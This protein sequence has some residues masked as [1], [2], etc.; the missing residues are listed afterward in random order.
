MKAKKDRMAAHEMG[1]D[2]G[3]KK[4]TKEP[5][6]PRINFKYDS[7]LGLFGF[8]IEAERQSKREN[9]ELMRIAKKNEEF[10]EIAR[11]RAHV[12]Y[13][14]GVMDAKTFLPGDL[15]Q[16][17]K[18]KP[19]P[20]K[21]KNG[22][23]IGKAAHDHGK[24]RSKSDFKGNNQR[25]AGKARRISSENRNMEPPHSI[26]E[27]DIVSSFNG[28]N[29]NGNAMQCSPID[30]D[31]R[32]KRKKSV[33]MN[34]AVVMNDSPAVYD[35]FYNDGSDF[36]DNY[37]NDDVLEVLEVNDH[38]KDHPSKP[39]RKGT[40]P[41]AKTDVRGVK[42]SPLRLSAIKK[43][44]Q[45]EIESN[46]ESD[47]FSLNAKPKVPKSG[48]KKESFQRNRPSINRSKPAG[49]K[50]RNKKKSKSPRRSP[51]KKSPCK[52]AQGHSSPGKGNKQTKFDIDV[53]DSVAGAE[54]SSPPK[55]KSQ[56]K[57]PTRFLK[58]SIK[59]PK[60]SIA[61]ELFEEFE[62]F[63]LNDD[64]STSNYAK[65]KNSSAVSGLPMSKT[66]DNEVFR[67]TSPS[68]PQRSRVDK[69][70]MALYAVKSEGTVDKKKDEGLDDYNDDGFDDYDEDILFDFSHHDK[71]D[72]EKAL[73]EELSKKAQEEAET[74]AREK[75]VKEAEMEK[76]RLE[77]EKR[78]AVEREEQR[79]AR[80]LA[81]E[82]EEAERIKRQEEI[83][84]D[85]SE[86][87]ESER[88]E[89]RRRQARL[90]E[91]ELA[92]KER[93]QVER[94]MKKEE[95]RLALIQAEQEA[96][97]EKQKEKEA[98]KRAAMERQ[99]KEIE[100]ARIAAE[101][102]EE[103]ERRKRI[104]I[105]KIKEEKL[106]K[107]ANLELERLPNVIASP[108]NIEGGNDEME[109]INS[110]QDDNYNFDEDFEDDPQVKSDQD[111]DSSSPVLFEI[112][113]PIR[114]SVGE[115]DSKSHVVS[116]KKDS[117]PASSKSTIVVEEVGLDN[118]HKSKDDD[119]VL[120]DFNKPQVQSPVVEGENISERLNSP[121]GNP[122]PNDEE[123]VVEDYESEYDDDF[124]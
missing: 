52:V 106:Q 1:I 5:V 31:V 102:K 21:V 79:K 16:Q 17:I 116:P 27:N 33:Q 36:I 82:K 30:G 53:F 57:S 101:E 78:K 72:E 32:K 54:K 69:E 8:D 38:D 88:M 6:S 62:A 115:S 41:P 56:T 103:E 24:L 114:T 59:E 124:D 13:G 107:A 51:R 71:T 65:S 66:N 96:V 11:A 89:E 7:R 68:S 108:K 100:D 10:A 86:R 112:N 44:H 75:T 95:E 28:G 111:I 34:P 9:Y 39:K 3:G 94:E 20:K 105:D 117:E 70:Q 77:N 121:E 119:D 55:V 47:R 120:F 40:P 109:E 113:S 91:E 29:G 61:D 87:L 12:K 81:K 46:P 84:R 76:L 35:D 15:E 97:L 80:Q 2:F 4:P 42:M 73:N 99:Q 14:A 58:K 74:I 93:E 49:A 83:A 48:D 45:Q 67:M 123:D 19:K 25:M 104:M 23:I 90:D 26:D 122:I 22:R 85:E 92:R 63:N 110:I 118:G 43:A 98:E 50:S 64:K 60:K 37:A 18:A